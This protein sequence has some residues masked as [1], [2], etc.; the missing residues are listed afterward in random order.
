MVPFR[1]KLVYKSV[2]VWAETLRISLYTPGV[3]LKKV[4]GNL[5]LEFGFSFVGI[6]LPD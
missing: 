2:R 4:Y 6:L 3:F 1:S 5:S